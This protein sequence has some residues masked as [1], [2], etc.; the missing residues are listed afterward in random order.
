MPGRAARL[1]AHNAQLA[2]QKAARR[3]EKQVLQA[4]QIRVVIAA[5]DRAGQ[6]VA[7]LLT[8]LQSLTN[9]SFGRWTNLV[10]I[11]SSGNYT[12]PMQEAVV[13]LAACRL[14]IQPTR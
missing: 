8:S 5:A 7:D 12:T 9:G 2:V 4:A 1:A 10:S 11:L 14:T 6:T 13:C 3:A